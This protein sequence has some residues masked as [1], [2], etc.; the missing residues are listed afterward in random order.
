MEENEL[1][2]RRRE[3]QERLESGESINPMEASDLGMG[4]AV[5]LTGRARSLANLNPANRKGKANPLNK[6][7]REVKE[8]LAEG[9]DADAILSALNDLRNMDPKEYV[10]MALQVLKYITPKEQPVKIE[11]QVIYK[12]I[13]L[14]EPGPRV[15]ELEQADIGSGAS[16]LPGA[17]DAALEQIT[18]D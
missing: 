4:Q 10:T 12:P 6:K 2:R 17:P 14:D 8:K 11:A 18:L 7:V 9:I 5:A 1:D 3:L 15:I 13:A 16:E